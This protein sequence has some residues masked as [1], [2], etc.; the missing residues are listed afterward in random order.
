[1][2][3]LHNFHYPQAAAA[4]RDAQQLDPGRRADA[5]RSY[6]LAAKNFAHADSSAMPTLTKLRARLDVEAPPAT[7]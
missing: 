4:F 3:Y 1:M 6:A 5:R 2:L 7:R